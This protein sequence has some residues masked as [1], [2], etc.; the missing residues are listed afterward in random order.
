MVN[1]SVMNITEA[2][3]RTRLPKNQNQTPFALLFMIQMD[4]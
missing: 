4:T 3:A 2:V 1:S